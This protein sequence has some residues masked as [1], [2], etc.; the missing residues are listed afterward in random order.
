[1]LSIDL[2]NELLMEATAMR[3]TDV[4]LQAGSPPLY[5]L[6]GALEAHGSVPVAMEDTLAL[7]K[8]IL[9]PDQWE[10]FEKKGGVQVVKATGK[11]AWR[12]VR[13]TRAGLNVL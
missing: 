11:A 13:P 1:M 3:C 8:N 10:R 12:K 2:V 4:H 6:S 9:R 7:L 5:R